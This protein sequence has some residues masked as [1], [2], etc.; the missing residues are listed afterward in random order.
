MP[1][2]NYESSSMNSAV[3]KYKINAEKYV[4]FLCSNNELSETEIKKTTPIT[5]APKIMKY[6]GINLPKE[7]KD[8]YS[9][10]L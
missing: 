8:L 9:E 2:E 6:I 3:S 5:I 10:K 4:A 7:A 1:P